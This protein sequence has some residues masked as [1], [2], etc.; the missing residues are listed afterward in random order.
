MAD[1]RRVSSLSKR[2]LVLRKDKIGGSEIACLVKMSRWASPIEIW[3]AKVL[4][5]E[6]EQTEAMRRGVYLEEP[7]ARMYADTFERKLRKVD[8]LVDPAYPAL[9]ATPDRAVFPVVPKSLASKKLLGREDL[10]EAECLLE[11]KSTT[12]RLASDWGEP[13][14][15]QIPYEYLPQVI[16][17]MG[18]SCLRRV[19]V[20]VLFD[21]DPFER[22]QVTFRAD[23]F[24]AFH[25]V[26][27]KFLRDHV[28]TGIPPPP[29][30]SDRYEE[31]LSR[32]Y[33]RPLAPKGKPIQASPQMVELAILWAK[34]RAAEA[35]IGSLESK[36]ANT[37]RAVIGPH[38]GVE[39][40]SFG[41]IYWTEIPESLATDWEA[42]G[43]EAFNLA[44]LVLQGELDPD[45]RGKLIEQLRTLESRHQ[46]VAR[47]AY[48][49]LAPYWNFE[50][51]EAAKQVGP[52]LELLWKMAL[53]AQAVVA[54]DEENEVEAQ[55]Q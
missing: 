45:A 24:E 7:I 14:T 50:A 5:R 20:G 34:V 49:R 53:E 29:D 2:Q 35:S 23:L 13:G 30:A 10:A 52:S 40:P 18:L 19:D 11:C 17:Q 33:P 9:I 47:K 15:D 16:V 12:W 25:E 54:P 48:R 8:T 32:A 22:Y 27:A 51:K 1:K 3:E 43:R 31:F 37:F 26:G 6:K 21:T 38:R 36:I 4:E 28:E 41:K 42:A 39:S 55:S 44:A 46:V